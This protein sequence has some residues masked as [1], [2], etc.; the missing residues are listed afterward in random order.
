LYL[1]IK[2]QTTGTNVLIKFLSCYVDTQVL[3]QS[4]LETEKIHSFK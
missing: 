3:G 4:K 2:L 1:A